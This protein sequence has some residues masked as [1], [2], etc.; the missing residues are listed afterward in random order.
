MKNLGHD[1]KREMHNNLL[2]YVFTLIELLVVIAIIAIL[3]ALLLPAL[4]SAKESVKQA[5]C[6]SNQ[7]Q[8]GIAFGNYLN[9]WDSSYPSNI[10][11]DENSRVWQGVFEEYKYV[12]ELYRETDLNYLWEPTGNLFCPVTHPRFIEWVKGGGRPG[13]QYMYNGVACTT[14]KYY[15][16]YAYPTNKDDAYNPSNTYLSLGGRR[17]KASMGL[18][19]VPYVKSTYVKS[20]FSK[21]LL[22]LGN[23][24]TYPTS[25]NKFSMNNQDIGTTNWFNLVESYAIHQQTTN[26]LWLDGHAD[27]RRALEI[28]Q[29]KNNYRSTGI[30]TY[31]NFQLGH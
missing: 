13:R 22:L 21:T 26:L 4:Q 27:Q 7:K 25:V 28:Y 14:E 6:L 1:T 2:S 10:Y 15:F 17:V 31:F 19:A 5:V 9:D 18:P 30:D 3:S 29:E 11:Y 23:I 12:P 8:L 24:N 20:D 16:S